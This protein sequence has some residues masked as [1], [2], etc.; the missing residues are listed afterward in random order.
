MSSC[1][2]VVSFFLFFRKVLFVGE[3]DI[4]ERRV[5]FNEI[6]CC[7]FK[8]V[9]LVGSLELLEF[10]GIRFLGVVGFISRDF[11]VLDGIDS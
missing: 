5:V 6:L 10:L 1:Y 11:F 2:V 3:F 8:D 9:E 4:W 7:V